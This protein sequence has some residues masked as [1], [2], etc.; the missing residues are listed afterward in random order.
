[1]ARVSGIDIP[2]NKRIEIALTSI[3]GIGDSVAC[4]I[5]GKAGVNPGTRTKDISTEDFARI[6][7]VIDRDYEI[8][9]E[10]LRRTRLNIKRLK[11]IGC[12]RGIRHEKGLP[13]RGQR[14]KTNARTRRGKRQVIRGAGTV[15]ERH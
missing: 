5:L 6:R 8:G 13:V 12:Y 7:K 2:D 1:M 3:R 10:L 9:G 4:E 11:D 14:T 15:K